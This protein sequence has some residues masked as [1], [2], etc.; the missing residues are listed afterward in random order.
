MPR[1]GRR[2]LRVVT[3]A[4]HRQAPRPAAASSRVGCVRARAGEVWHLRGVL[5]AGSRCA[6]MSERRHLRVTFRGV[7]GS[8]PWSRPDAAVHGCNTSCV[9]VHDAASGAI[10]IL[11]AGSG[12][13]GAEPALLREP[14]A[15]SL[16]LTHYH[17]DH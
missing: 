16:L 12:I 7:R 11:D 10:L 4:L 17:W 1:E 3:A 2:P 13:V 15:V 9:E 8:V 5:S 6:A 14:R